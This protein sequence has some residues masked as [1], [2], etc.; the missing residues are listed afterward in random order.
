MPPASSAP[1]DSIFARILRTTHLAFRFLYFNFLPLSLYVLKISSNFFV[2]FSFYRL[3]V[4]GLAHVVES[5]HPN[6][7]Q[8]RA[9]KGPEKWTSLFHPETSQELWDEWK[10]HRRVEMENSLVNRG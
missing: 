3:Y 2:A 1:P 7:L 5:A 9:N 10:R 4:I 8:I 6:R